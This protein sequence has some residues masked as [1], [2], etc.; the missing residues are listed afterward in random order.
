M[1]D[2]NSIKT[3]NDFWS[4]VVEDSSRFYTGEEN[5]LFYDFIFDV[6][7]WVEIQAVLN[8]E[9][10]RQEDKIE[11]LF[12]LTSVIIAEHDI[13]QNEN[14]N[15]RNEKRLGEFRVWVDYNLKDILK[16]SSE[17]E[18]Q[19]NKFNGDQLL[20]ETYLID[21]SKII[22][23][24]KEF[25]GDLFDEMTFIEYLNCFNLDLPEPIHP[26]FIR[27]QGINFVYFLSK[28]GDNNVVN[29]KIAE[30]RF[31]L[32]HFKQRKSKAIPSTVFINKVN[33]ILK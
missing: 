33:S 25:N 18:T 22:K 8:Y 21:I 6:K 10:E 17:V 12:N 14:W 16:Q 7:G 23:S 13:R 11:H 30:D 9:L 31:G 28:I 15:Q 32:K 27:N 24:Y 20:S 29:D 19:Q 4:R 2:F 1:I 5:A 26:K 3:S